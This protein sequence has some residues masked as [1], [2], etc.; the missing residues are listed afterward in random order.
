MRRLVVDRHLDDLPAVGVGADQQLLQDVVAARVVVRGQRLAPHQARR[1]RQIGDAE[2]QPAA[3]DAVER[4]AQAAAERRHADGRAVHEARADEDLALI[5]RRPQPDDGGTGLAQVGVDDEDPLAAGPAQAVDEGDAVAVARR[6]LDLGL[7]PGLARRR[8][9]A[10]RGDDD[11]FGG[12]AQRAERGVQAGGVADLGRDARRQDHDDRELGRGRGHGQ[13][14]AR[15]GSGA[16][17]SLRH[18]VAPLRFHSASS[19]AALTATADSVLVAFF[20]PLRLVDCANGSV[21]PPAGR[22]SA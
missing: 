22:K 6:G 11:G 1:A 17:G 21:R 16:S 13:R 5:A 19:T 8:H 4:A 9:V 10:R 15:G 14:G 2:A 12:A 18:G 7:G 20:S 3:E